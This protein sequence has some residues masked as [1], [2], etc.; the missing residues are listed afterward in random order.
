M[1]KAQSIEEKVDELDFIKI[2]DFCSSKDA[3]KRMKT[4]H[5]EWEEMFANYIFDK[6]FVFRIY[7]ELSNLKITKTSNPI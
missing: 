2:N 6:R 4:Q 5:A 3:V 7:N 1:P